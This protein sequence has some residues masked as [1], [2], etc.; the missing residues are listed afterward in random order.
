MAHF[1]P[2]SYP[3]FADK[4]NERAAHSPADFV[5]YLRSTG[6]LSG[7]EAPAGV[8]LCYQRSLYNHMLL[9]EGLT[10]PERRDALHG[11]VLLPSTDGRVGVLGQ[12]GIGAPAAAVVLE[13]LAAAGTHSFISI[14]TAGSLQHDLQIGDLVLC[15]AA[16]RDEGVSHHYL[17]PGKFANPAPAIT[18]TFKMALKQA[19]APVRTGV[20]WTI[21]T[22]YRET[23]AEIA[24]YQSE[25]VLCV[26]MEAAALFAVAQVRGLQIA[27]GFA[28]SDRLAG[29][30]WDPQF[31]SPQVADSLVVLYEAAL[32]TLLAAAP[33]QGRAG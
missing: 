24:R 3:N 5:A 31:H 32:T 25:G 8:I 2:A 17:P 15:G 4:H 21:D 29:L 30:I 28:V 10:R 7:Y 6:G 14:G 16:I 19:G 13:E 22:P 11:V 18:A 1:E 27:A 23:V 20:S 33:R 12:F 26:E 9:S